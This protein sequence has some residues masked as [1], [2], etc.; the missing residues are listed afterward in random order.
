MVLGDDGIDENGGDAPFE[1]EH[2]EHYE[3][4]PNGI[5]DRDALDEVYGFMD[6]GHD[7]IW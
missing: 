3:T 6:F 7:G 5:F 1:D 2:H 4:I